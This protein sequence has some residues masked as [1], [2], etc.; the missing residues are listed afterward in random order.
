[1]LFGS[2]ALVTRDFTIDWFC[3]ERP[4]F[5]NNHFHGHER[6][7]FVQPHQALVISQLSL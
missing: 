2:K 6:D 4:L 7:A 1:M 3:V 5:A